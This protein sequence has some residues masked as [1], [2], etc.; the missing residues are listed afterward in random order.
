MSNWM[1][2]MIFVIAV[3]VTSIAVASIGNY[4][5]AN[6]AKIPRGVEDEMILIPRFYNSENCFAYKD[7]VGRVHMHVIDLNKFK[8]EN[9]QKCFLESD[10]NYAF[11]LSLEVSEINLKLGPINTFNWVEGFT[12][13]EIE[14]RVIVLKD[15]LRYGAKLKIGIKN[16]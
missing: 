11:S 2:W 13:K 15:N 10:I 8:Q 6:A 12:P 3:G 5:V 7:E 1:I 16:V 14:E 4:F 9:M